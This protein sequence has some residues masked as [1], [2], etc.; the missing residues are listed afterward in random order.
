M[1]QINLVVLGVILVVC[2]FA[3]LIWLAVSF[4]RG[5]SQEDEAGRKKLFYNLLKNPYVGR[6]TKVRNQCRSIKNNK[7]RDRKGYYYGSMKVP[8]N[9]F[10]VDLV[11]E[12]LTHLCGLQNAAVVSIRHIGVT[13]SLA[14]VKFRFY[15]VSQPTFINFPQP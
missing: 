3:Y 9:K 7:C 14:Q 5:F 4:K 13:K 10:S 12:F 15:D 6:E 1:N 2:L 8:S 11:E